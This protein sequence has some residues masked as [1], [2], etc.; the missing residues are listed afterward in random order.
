MQVFFVT[1]MT[2]VNMSRCQCVLMIRLLC[3]SCMPHF[4]FLPVMYKPWVT[5]SLLLLTVF[6]LHQSC[7]ISS[8]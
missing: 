5:R 3:T 8:W 6:G 7:K 4:S 1:C 2:D